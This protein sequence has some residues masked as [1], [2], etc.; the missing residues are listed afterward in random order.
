MLKAIIVDGEEIEGNSFV[1]TGETVVTAEFVKDETPA[2][3]C[4]SRVNVLG[5]IVATMAMLASALFI[6]KKKLAD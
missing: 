4:G 6:V 2:G 5:G 3:G 1:V